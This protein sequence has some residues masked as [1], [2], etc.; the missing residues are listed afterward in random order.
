MSGQTRGKF[1][2]E[3]EWAL[4][5]EEDQDAKTL[6]TLAQ[7]YTIRQEHCTLALIESVVE[8]IRKKMPARGP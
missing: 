5:N 3:Y 1:Q 2:D 7:L 6:I 8:S 4:K